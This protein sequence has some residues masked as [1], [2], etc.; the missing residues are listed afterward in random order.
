MEAISDMHLEPERVYKVVSS[1][2]FFHP[3]QSGRVH[4]DTSP[5]LHVF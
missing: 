5:G 3:P 2:A 4:T 1:G